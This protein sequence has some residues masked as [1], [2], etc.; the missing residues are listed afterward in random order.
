MRG[1]EYTAGLDRN[2]SK[3]DEFATSQEAAIDF[4]GA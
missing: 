1:F 3:S 4:F 2:R